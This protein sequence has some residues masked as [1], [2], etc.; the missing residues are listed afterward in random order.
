METTG[1]SKKRIALGWALSILPSVM[2]LLGI[3]MSLT[4]NPQATEGMV[5]Y[6]FSPGVLVPIAI[7]ELI[8]I[9]LYLVPPTAV[10]GAVLLTAYL[11]GAVV[12]H[13]RMGEWSIMMAPII[14]CLVFWA[15]IYLREPR[16]ADLLPLR[17]CTRS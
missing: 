16:L 11:G 14:V 10:L 1:S 5:K 2:F 13:L 6:G 4:K 12:T 7:V 8:C 17:R 15:G 3:M 9:V